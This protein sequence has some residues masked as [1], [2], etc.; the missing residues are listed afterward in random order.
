MVF[1]FFSRFE[2]QKSPFSSV[3]V[4]LVFFFGNNILILS[5]FW[6]VSCQLV[7]GIL[8]PTRI[9]FIYFFEVE[10]LFLSLEGSLS[11]PLCLSK[12]QE[13]FSGRSCCV[14]KQLNDLAATFEEGS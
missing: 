11:S 2:C 8:F 4:V 1:R 10:V 6:L 12:K 14:G 7:W 3:V 9:G 13:G 5:V